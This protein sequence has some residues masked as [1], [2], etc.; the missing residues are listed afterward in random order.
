MY[1]TISFK[2]LLIVATSVNHRRTIFLSLN[3]FKMNTNFLFKMKMFF[4]LSMFIPF[5][6]ISQTKNIFFTQRVFPKMDKVLEFEKALSAHAKKYHTGDVAWRVFEIQSGPDMGGYQ[7]TEG[8]TS[9]EALDTRGNLGEE[10]TIDWNKT[11]AVYLTDKM[12]GSYSVYQDTLS[13]VALSDFSDK[14]QITHVYPKIGKGNKVRDIIKNLKAA[15][16]AEGSTIAVY[17]TSSSGPG[18]YVL[19][20]RYKQGLKEKA[21][22]FRKPFKDTYEAVYGV[23]SFEAYLEGV[24][25][26]TSEVWSELLFLRKELG[27]K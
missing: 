8:P 11:V 2:K 3:K 14:I 26:F 13:T 10:H 16:V 15:W 25:Q 21:E 22:G 9:W 1:V 20:T 24:S 6:G 7:I 18:Q 12:S 4:L 17:T 5:M 23:G 27:S 19:V